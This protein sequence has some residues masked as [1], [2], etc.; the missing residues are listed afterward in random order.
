[1]QNGCQGRRGGRGEACDVAHLAHARLVLQEGY[2]RASGGRRRCLSASLNVALSNSAA[3]R[4]YE[5]QGFKRD[6]V[7]EDYYGPGRPGVRMILDLAEWRE[8]RFQL[9]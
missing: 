6:A 8:R 9:Q 3:L 4:L 2:S 1:M 7:L 5:A